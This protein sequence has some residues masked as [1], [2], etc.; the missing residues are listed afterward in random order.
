MKDELAKDTYALLDAAGLKRTRGRIAV[1]GVLRVAQKPLAIEGIN[2]ALVEPVHLVTLYR[3][4]RQFVD[5]GIVYQTDLRTGKA[6]YELQ[7]KHHHHVTCTQCGLQEEFSVCITPLLDGITKKSKNFT[8]V[9]GHTLE[10]FGLC[11]KCTKKKRSRSH[12][13]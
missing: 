5:A 4:L 12:T 1:L 2:T 3:M 13:N 7:Q 6:Y 8:S 9:A 10:L 11:N